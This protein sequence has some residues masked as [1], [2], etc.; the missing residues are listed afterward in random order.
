MSLGDQDGYHELHIYERRLEDPRYT[1]LVQSHIVHGKRTQIAEHF[2]R[3][4]PDHQIPY[5][6]DKIAT[7]ALEQDFKERVARVA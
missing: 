5:L 7:T 6:H 3:I 2:W 1:K 4:L